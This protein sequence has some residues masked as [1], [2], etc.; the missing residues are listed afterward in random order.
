MSRKS[1]KL[2]S[3]PIRKRCDKTL[4]TSVINSPLSPPSLMERC[5]KYKVEI[6]CLQVL[7]Q[8]VL[9]KK[10]SYSP[11]DLEYIMNDLTD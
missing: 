5:I 1:Q 8:G 11:N 7:A 3:T 9:T 2:L 4:G 10:P 6:N